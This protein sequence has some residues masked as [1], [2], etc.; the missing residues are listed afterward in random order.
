MILV[1][2]S[3]LIVAW[4]ALAFG[5]V[6]PW[7]YAPLLAASAAAGAIGL[8]EPGRRMPRASRRVII[9]LLCVGG[10]AAVQLVPMT[11]DI[12]EAISPATAA[13]LRNYTL[14]YAVEPFAH[15]LSVDP[16]QTRRGLLFLAAF[17][18]LLAGLAR[19]LSRSRVRTLTVALV[20]LG[21]A[22]AAIGILQK[23]ILGDHT[24]MGMK[25]YGFWTPESKLVVPFGPYVNRNHFA[26]WMLM[27]LP[28]AI[29]YLC[30]LFEEGTQRSAG[31]RN[32]MLWLS[33][34][35]GGG[36][37]LVLT[38]SVLMSVSLVM[39]MSR[40]G[41]AGFAIAALL[42]GGRLLL[43][44]RS[45]TSRFIAVLA[46]AL[47]V[48]VPAV[49][50]GIDPTV[51]RLSTDPRGSVE[52]R[53]RVWRDAR[54]IAAD[55]PLAGTGLNTF[56]TAT[57][58]YQTGSRDVHFQE[59]HNDYLQLAAEGGLLLALPIV[60]VV[61]L[62]GA[63][64]RKRMREDADRTTSWI[65]FGAVAGIIAIALQSLVE[66]SLQMPG[67]AAMF[68]V[69]LAISIHYGA[70]RGSPEG[71]RYRILPGGPDG[72]RHELVSGSPEGPRRYSR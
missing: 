37:L 31:W 52:T 40:S 45:A 1:I 41:M 9:G 28:L 61:V 63:A 48:I 67:N 12:L 69:L 44:L 21:A 62:F 51:E 2:A 39:S 66:F 7:A 68:V 29:G 46:L 22:L 72:S 13:F 53:L 49:S 10:A 58:L 17:T 23:A 35:S 25:I 47:L 64:V 27:G 57:V 26:G 19:G 59:A 18:L 56:G 8:L 54:S 3:I 6:Y 42:I 16:A 43:A 36:A 5:A 11:P 24:Y 34:P 71:L 65:R 15:P 60:V 14:R 4:G 20:V 55:F 30:A 38:A 50:I 33:T 70:R 32:R